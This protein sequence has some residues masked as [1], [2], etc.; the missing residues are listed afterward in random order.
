MTKN[1]YNGWYNYETWAVALW[2]DNEEGSQ[3]YWN[4]QAS[5][6]L[7]NAEIPDYMAGLTWSKEDQ[8]TKDLADLLKEQHEEQAADMLERSKASCSIMADLLNAALSEV[9]W[10]EVAKHFID[11]AQE[12]IAD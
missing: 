10:H 5:E 6:L 1:E 4:E 7:T 2:I 9:N 12:R 3:N 11:A 8:A